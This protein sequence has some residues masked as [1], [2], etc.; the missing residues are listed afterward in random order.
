[1]TIKKTIG[2]VLLTGLA[3]G[4]IYAGYLMAG[5]QAMIFALMALGIILGTFALLMLICWLIEDRP[6]ST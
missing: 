4:M 1:M 2:Y 5:I 6:K 3:T